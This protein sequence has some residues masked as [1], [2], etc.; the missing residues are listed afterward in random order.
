YDNA[1]LYKVNTFFEHLFPDP[2]RLN[3]Y[4]QKSYYFYTSDHGQ[5]LYRDQAQHIHCGDTHWEA[6]VQLILFGQVAQPLDTAYDASHGNVFTTILDMMAVP[7]SERP[8]DYPLSLLAATAAASDDR[9]FFAGSVDTV[10]NY[11]HIVR[12]TADD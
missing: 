6:S 10:K 2:D 12:T 9:W 4:T 8:Y 5:T 7:V 3:E 1:F 11:D